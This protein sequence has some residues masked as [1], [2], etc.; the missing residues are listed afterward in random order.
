RRSGRTSRDV[1]PAAAF[2]G[3]SELDGGKSGAVF[4]AGNVA[5]D[6]GVGA[7]H[8][9]AHVDEGAGR[10]QPQHDVYGLSRRAAE[11]LGANPPDSWRQGRFSPPRGDGPAD[12]KAAS[13]CTA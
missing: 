11:D 8:D 5:A 13:P 7:G 10:M 3:L 4:C 9:A 12:G 1:P 6:A 2:E